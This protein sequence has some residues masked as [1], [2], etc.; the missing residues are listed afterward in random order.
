MKTPDQARWAARAPWPSW[1]PRAA[2]A[3]PPPRR[4]GPGAT[5]A[6]CDRGARPRPG[7][8]D[9]PSSGE[10]TLWHS[11]GSGGGETGAFDQVL[12]RRPGAEPGA[13]DQRRRAAVQ[14]HLQQV[15]DGRAGRRGDPRPVHRPER[16]PVQPVRRRRPRRRDRA[17][18]REARRLLAGRGRRLAG[19]RQVLHGPRVPQGRGH[20]V[21]QDR[22]SRPP[23]PPPTSSSPASRTA[24]SSSASTRT[25]TTCSASAARSA[26]SSW[27]PPASASPTRAASPMRSSTSP[28]SRQPAPSSTR[29]AT[30]S[31][32]TS[33]PASSNAV[34][35]GPWQTADFT[36]AFATLGHELAVAPIP[37]GPSGAKANPFT[38]T[39]GWYINP[40][41]P[42]VD[43]AVAV[44]ADH[45][46]HD[47]G[48]DLR[49]LRRPRPRG[50]RRHHR[51][52][53]RPGLRRRGGRRASRARS[54]ASSTTT[55][56]PS[57]TRSTR[58]STRARI[59]PTT[60]T[61]ACKPM[62]DASGLV[63]F[64]IERPGAPSQGAPGLFFARP[65]FR[66]L[67]RVR[68]TRILRTTSRARCRRG[69]PS[70][71]ATTAMAPPRDAPGG[72][73][74][75]APSQPYLYL[76]PA[77]I[78]MGIITFYPLIFQVWMSFT[79]FGPK[80][81]R[82]NNPIAPT[83]VGLDNYYRIA[84][85]KL[86]IPNFEFLRLVFFNLWWAFSNVVIHV[87][88]GVLVAVLLNTKGLMFRGFYRALFILPGG[89]PAAHRGD[90]L[91]E[92]VRHGRR[93]RELP[94]S[95]ASAASSACR[96]TRPASTSTGCARRTT[97]SRSS[98]CRWPTSRCSS[99]TPGS[100]GR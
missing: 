85:S 60:I 25:P 45:G 16:Q 31:S 99:R 73:S 20:V 43:L 65:G 64:A 6:A 22:R 90:G 9:W 59:P 100:A 18:R 82:V 29:T 72:R 30:P 67:P 68:R 2:P 17:A 32:R 54:R 12:A 61:D 58:S 92:H 97:R 88:L 39:D 75:G 11:Y 89:H 52:P 4:A 56:A 7:P 66:H 94:A 44:R 14:R 76:L 26:A 40:N 71:M 5:H 19:R 13:D 23:R 55:G 3:A 50:A 42:N 8:V 53:D 21:R 15:A 47:L 93:R 10:L 80:N 79:D 70:A 77:F 98:R 27:T 28:T 34:I 1:P 74:S 37:A 57:A 81:F 83:F 41:S 91:A 51:R 87:I 24:R 46:Q 35:D 49:R 33:R 48:A 36:A 86:Q 69:E 96:P 84:T 95:R 63:A 38:G 62:N 78:V